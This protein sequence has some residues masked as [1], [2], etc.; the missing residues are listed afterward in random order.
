MQE[1]TQVRLKDGRLALI[2]QAV[3]DDAQAATNFVNIVTSEKKYLLRE[4]ATWTID[5]ERRTIAAADGKESVFFVAEIDGRLS[6]SINLARGRWPKN[7]HVAELA[8]SCLPSCRGVGLGT[9]LMT[10]GIE[11]ARSVGVLKLT[12]Q[13]FATNKRAIALYEKMGFEE[14]ARLREHFR[15]DGKLFDNILMAL[16]LKPIPRANKPL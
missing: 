15:F 5:E 4:R 14:E 7:K 10:R 6:G 12:L 2:R 13:V 11:W 1:A 9:A 8:I 3:P 16:W